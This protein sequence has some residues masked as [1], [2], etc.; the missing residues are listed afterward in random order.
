[1]QFNLPPGLLQSVCYTESR[2]NIN[3]VHHDDGNGDSLGVCQI[4]FKTAKWLG[5]K[6]TAQ[7]LMNPKTNIYYAAKYIRYN[8]NRYRN[9]ARAVI[10]YNLGH[11][12]A[13]TSTNYQRTVFKVWTSTDASNAAEMPAAAEKR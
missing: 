4:K 6:G 9:A 8:I 7:Q 13:L 12:G 1:M 11:A 5:F 2:Y 3:A 10:A